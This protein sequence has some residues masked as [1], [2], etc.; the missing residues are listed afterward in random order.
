MEILV[1]DFAPNR[2]GAGSR[3]SVTPSW[4]PEWEDMVH[5]YPTRIDL[6]ERRQ[7]QPACA[8]GYQSCKPSTSVKPS[9]TICPKPMP[10]AAAGN[11]G[12]AR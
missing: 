5:L 8:D 7:T 4:A 12:C 6:S 10:V 11:V 9:R 3:F 2:F 1:A